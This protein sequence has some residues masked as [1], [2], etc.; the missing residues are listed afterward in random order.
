VIE[1]RRSQSPASRKTIVAGGIGAHR[2][3]HEEDPATNSGRHSGQRK[4]AKNTKQKTRGRVWMKPPKIS[5]HAERQDNQIYESN[6]PKI[7]TR[8]KNG[9]KGKGQRGRGREEAARARDIRKIASS[10]S[11]NRRGGRRQQAAN[12]PLTR[13]RGSL[14]T[15]VRR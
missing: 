9:T 3:G 8:D 10:R 5:T 14:I 1:G 4:S 7:P 12:P 6:T 15:W 11:K 13:G 2:R